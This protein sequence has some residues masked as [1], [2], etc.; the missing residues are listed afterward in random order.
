MY[1]AFPKCELMAGGVVSVGVEED[2]VDA[3]RHL[4]QER[5]MNVADPGEAGPNAL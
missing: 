2:G 5:L 3:P 4:R 1:A